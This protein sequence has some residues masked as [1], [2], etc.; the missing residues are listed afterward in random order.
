[1]LS[2]FGPLGR[3]RLI[4]RSV[5]SQGI[6]QT[7]S[8]LFHQ[9][10]MSSRR[11]LTPLSMMCFYT[12]IRCDLCSC[13][14]RGPMFRLVRY[15]QSMVP[16]LDPF[17]SRS[18]RSLVSPPLPLDGFIPRLTSSRLT[19]YLQ[20]LHNRSILNFQRNLKLNSEGI[21]WL[22]CGPF[23]GVDRW[24]LSGLECLLILS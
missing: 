11:P 13:L 5:L 1:M 14:R 16:R 10:D 8:R 21:P 9:S 3:Q 22:S 7:S 23:L 24:P 20:K 12:P 19:L 6:V 18:G 4:S 2:F 15:S 17:P